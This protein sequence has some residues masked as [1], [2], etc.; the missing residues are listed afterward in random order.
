MGREMDLSQPDGTGSVAI[1]NVTIDQSGT[2]Y[3]FEGSIEGYGT[4]Y[5]TQYWEALDEGRT[6]GTMEG[7]ARVLG[8][9]GTLVS[10]PLRGT[11][12]RNGTKAELFFTDCVS[13]GD[14]NFV[15][16]EVDFITKQVSVSYYSLND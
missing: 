1:T 16:W 2:T 9:D 14:M 11:F 10:S 8:N 5:S 13:N 15:R 12:R 7:E 4:V 6:R 3:N